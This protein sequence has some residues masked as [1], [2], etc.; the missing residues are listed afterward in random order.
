MHV[1]ADPRFPTPAPTRR[2]P[3]VLFVLFITHGETDRL[4]AQLI[5]SLDSHRRKLCRLGVMTFSQQAQPTR[6]FSSRVV[7]SALQLVE[8]V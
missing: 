5:V 7:L 3:P 4:Y 6:P 2:H 1:C 8:Q